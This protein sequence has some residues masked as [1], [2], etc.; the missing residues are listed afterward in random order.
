VFVWGKIGCEKFE[1]TLRAGFGGVSE[2][3]FGAA[4]YATLHERAMQKQRAFRPKTDS[5][6]NSLA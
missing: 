4:A 1:D 2:K 6:C 3:D 5:S